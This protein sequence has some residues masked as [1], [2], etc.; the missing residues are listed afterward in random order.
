MKAMIISEY[1][2]NAKF[3]SK[4]VEKPILKNGQVLVKISASSV[5]T[6]DT[7]IKNMGNDCLFLPKVQQ[8]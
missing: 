2:E 1:G 6:V 8:F 3:E 7:M 5:N 4:K